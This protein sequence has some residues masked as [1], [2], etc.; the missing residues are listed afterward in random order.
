MPSESDWLEDWLSLGDAIPRYRAS[1]LIC[2]GLTPEPRPLDRLL[3]ASLDLADGVVAW[4]ADQLPRLGPAANETVVELLT[5]GKAARYLRQLR[6]MDTR[7]TRD[8]SARVTP[9]PDRR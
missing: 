3:E 2:L 1:M 5:S 8:T 9:R 4:L 7:D 6:P